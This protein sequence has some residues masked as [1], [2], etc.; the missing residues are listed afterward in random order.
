L[1][2]IKPPRLKKGDLI[3]LVS[4]AGT[5]LPTEKIDGAVRYLE[6]VGY[7]AVVGAN[8]AKVHG[9]LAGTDQERAADLNAFIKDERI[10]AIF[11][12]R[13][14]Y[15]TPRILSLVDYR[16]LKKK[17]K[18]ISGFS[19]I[20][21]LQLAVYKKCNL[22]TFSGP[23]PAVEFWKNPDAYTEEHFWR[24]VTSKQKA[25]FLPNPAGEPV[26]ILKSGKTA[27][28]LLGGN[29]ALVTAAV[30]TAFLPSM[31]NVLLVLEEVEEQ[32][33]RVDRMFAQLNNAGILMGI[34]GLVLGKF[35]NCVPKD[36]EKPSLS[37]EQV[38]ADYAASVKGPVVANFQY[39]HVAKK[40][41][42][43]FGVKA[44]LDATKGTLEVLESAVQ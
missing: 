31:R 28:V 24:L 36:P 10:K 17:P 44:R 22:V 19:D 15:G 40:L 4:P 38:L 18:I 23:M 39:G 14:G 3:G 16:S 6:S 13:G 37:T 8:A 5:P 20:T 35:T 27:G 30:G 7:R 2:A 26:Q 25:G 32:P 12:L 34:K 11:A 9:Y 33:Y 21:G 43:P 29:L 41:T 42:V 1:N